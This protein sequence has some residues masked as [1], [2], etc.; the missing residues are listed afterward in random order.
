VTARDIVRIARQRA[1][2][3]QQQLADRSGHPRETIARWET[4]AREPSLSS[5]RKLAEASN[6]EL[7]VHLA[8][9]DPSLGE[10][11]DDQLELSPLQRLE[12]LLPGATRQEAIRAL[13]WLA[14]ARTPL[15]VIGG[16]AAV[17]QGAPQG[18]GS[19]RVEFVSAD[20]FAIEEEMRAGGLVAIDT[21]ERWADT[22]ARALWTV[23]EGGTLALASNVPGTRD[24]GDLRR[25]AR[26]VELDE[27]ASLRVAHP[28]DLLRIADAS[29]RESERARAPGLRALLE[30]TTEP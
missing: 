11:V 30:R 19:E 16:M 13:R 17:L 20:P 21:D 2:L 4:G 7:V 24:Y 3:S 15:I 28:R 6:L 8:E 29:P 9:R 14:A 27:G 1:G 22:D 5:L 25:S 23:T 26:T 18:P 12:R 10:S